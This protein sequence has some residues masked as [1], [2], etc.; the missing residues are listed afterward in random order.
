MFFISSVKMT[1]SHPVV[2]TCIVNQKH[3][4]VFEL[5]TGASCNILPFVDYVKATRGKN[6]QETKVH[7][8]MHNNSSES[9]IGK[10]MLLV[11]HSD[12]S[13]QP[14]VLPILGNDACKS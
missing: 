13:H 6:I 11:R 2:A 12:H 9:L 10:V 3:Q 5:D 14:C 1:S 4:V 8:M 7:L